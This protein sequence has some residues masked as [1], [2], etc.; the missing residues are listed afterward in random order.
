MNATCLITCVY[1]VLVKTYLG[2]SDVSA[3]EDINWTTREVTFNF[4]L[5]PVKIIWTH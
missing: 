1:T 3:V 2:R 5:L 4:N